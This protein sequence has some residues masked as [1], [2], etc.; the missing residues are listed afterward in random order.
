[1]NERERERERAE[2]EEG[3]RKI[4]KRE[5]CGRTTRKGELGCRTEIDQ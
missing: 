4:G 2:K 1:M 3:K 5:E